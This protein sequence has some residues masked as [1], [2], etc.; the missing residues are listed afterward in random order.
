MF[1][2]IF[3]QVLSHEKKTAKYFSSDNKNYND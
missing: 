3:N 2:V 1:A